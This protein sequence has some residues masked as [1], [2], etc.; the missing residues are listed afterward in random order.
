M[1]AL[2]VRNPIILAADGYDVNDP[3]I[4]AKIKAVAARSA[5]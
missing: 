3:K 4:A 5:K 2:K 1:T